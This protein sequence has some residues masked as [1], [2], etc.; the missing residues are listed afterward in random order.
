M[1]INYAPLVAAWNGAT[2]PPTGT[3]GAPLTGGMTTQQKIDTVNAWTVTGPAQK[4][5]LSPSAVLNA[6]VFA[7]LAALT[8]LQVS[9]LTLL[10]AGNSVD[11]SAGTSIRLGVQQLFVGKT[12]TLTNLGALV[13]PYDSPK[14]PWW[15]ANGFAGPIN[16]NDAAAAGI[17]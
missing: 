7:D 12:Q 11:A 10:L 5:V 6:I 4:A 17:S 14:I 15:Q 1:A 2:Q 3:T 8:Q 13:A 9:Q 16:A